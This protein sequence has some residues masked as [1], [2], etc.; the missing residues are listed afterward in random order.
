MKCKLWMVAIIL[1]LLG[2]WVWAI[3]PEAARKDLAQE[4]I[5]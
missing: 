4:N 1:I 5:P 3:T 2:N